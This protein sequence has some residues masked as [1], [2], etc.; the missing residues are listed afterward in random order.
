MAVSVWAASTQDNKSVPTVGSAG[1]GMQILQTD[2]SG[3]EL[4]GNMLGQNMMNWIIFPTDSGLWANDIDGNYYEYAGSWLYKNNAES[5][6]VIIQ[7][8]SD[9][10]SAGA[11]GSKMQGAADF[12]LTDPTALKV[13]AYINHA[14]PFTSTNFNTIYG[15]RLYARLSSDNGDFYLLAEV[16]FEKGIKGDGETDWTPWE[17]ASAEFDHDT[18]GDSCTTGL[19]SAPPALLTYKILNG[20]SPGDIPDSDRT[21]AKDRLVKFKTGLVANSRAYIGNVEIN[22]RPYGDR[23]L[24]SPIFQYDVF[25]EDNYLDVAINDGDQITALAAHGDRILQF[26]NSAV[27]IINVSKELEFLE[28]EQQGAGV[29][30]QAAVTTTPFGV[31]WVNTNGCYLYDGEKITQ[32]Q[33]GKIS[34]DDWND[35][36]GSPNVTSL[37]IIGYDPAHQQVVVVW[38]SNSATNAYVFDAETGG[39]HKVTGIINTTKNATNM[40]NARGDKLLVGGGA[41]VN[42]VNFLA[43]R[44]AAVS[45][46]NLKTKVFDFGNP[47][48]KKNLLE[49]AVI[50]KYGNAALDI[51]I[52]TDDGA[53][54]TEVGG[55]TDTDS[56]IDTVEFDM[57][58]TAAFQGKKTFQIEIEGTCDHRFELYSITLT[59]RDLGVH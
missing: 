17:A 7:D 11:F 8:G 59:Y 50:Y 2:N 43:D 35:G 24:K 52:S 20:F 23:I 39:W 13:Q 37:A 1:T 47:E 19:I 16:N 12:G 32:L 5:D 58:G 4:D 28:D 18:V 6:L 49:V 40:T 48:S 29:A 51:N 9:N 31:V 54:F 14:T 56:A 22:G 30:F 46:F 26:K 44:T 57:S 3:T 38:D 15:G 10:G 42:D 34:S 25:T 55:L 53:S 33:L 41:T 45:G 21:G 27:Y 36:S